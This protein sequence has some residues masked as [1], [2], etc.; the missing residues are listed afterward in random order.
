[1]KGNY[2]GYLV[3]A[4]VSILVGAVIGVLLLNGAVSEPFGEQKLIDVITRYQMCEQD[5][6]PTEVCFMVPLAVDK[7]EL[8]NG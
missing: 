2:F 3:V 8:A 7:K 1:M 6:K 4:L 5:R